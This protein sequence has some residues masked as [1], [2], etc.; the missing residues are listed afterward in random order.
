MPILTRPMTEEQIDAIV[1]RPGDGPCP[2]VEALINQPI[3]AAAGGEPLRVSIFRPAERPAA[4]AP[5]VLAFHGGGWQNGDPNGC[6]ALAK[7]LAVRLNLTTVSASY[8]LATRQRTAFPQVLDDGVYAWKWVQSQAETLRIDPR[9]VAVSGESA[10]VLLAAHLAIGS[11]LIRLETNHPRPAA[12][13]SNWGTMDFVARW[14]D[15]GEAA[16]PEQV[17]FGT[18]YLADP[19]LYHR[20]SPI[21]YASGQLP[22]ALFA[23]GRQDHQVHPRQGQLG[24]SAWQ[25]AGAHAELRIIRNIGH[26]CQ[27]DTRPARL[28]WLQTV[29]DFV[30]AN[31]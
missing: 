28:E 16:G 30:A 13:L 5:A 6:G 23:Y 1:D 7:Y 24:L 19:A 25:A 29:A 8:R 26:D 10:G 22:P 14:Y 12:L 2:G 21:T 20:A 31:L 18:H 3:G 17:L 15:K 11:P 4:L 9:R 27:G